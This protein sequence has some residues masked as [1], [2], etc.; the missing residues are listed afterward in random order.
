MKNQKN[1]KKKGRQNLAQRQHFVTI[2]EPCRP[3]H[4]TFLKSSALVNWKIQLLYD[5]R[6]I[7]EMQNP[8]G[9]WTVLCFYQS[10]KNFLARNSVQHTKFFFLA[11]YPTSSS[12]RPPSS[13]NAL[14]PALSH[15]ATF[16]SSSKGHC[17]F[18]SIPFH[19]FIIM[20]PRRCV[21]G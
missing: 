2:V 18:H 8:K 1:R 12:E 5:G 14:P 6:G 13:L 10:T 7:K 15:W 4:L 19:A 3:R 9:V 11:P 16:S 17:D 20:H 21:S